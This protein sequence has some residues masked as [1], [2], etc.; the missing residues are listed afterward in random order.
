ML[1]YA[2][3]AVTFLVFCVGV[4]RDR[5]R[6][7]NAVLLG[8]SLVFALAAWCFTL[9][10]GGTLAGR[11]VAVAAVVVGALCVLVPAPLLLANG[12]TM[13]RKEGR[14]PA[15]LLSLLAG[16]GLFALAALLV[17]AFVLH[18]HTLLAI[19][20]TTAAIAGYVGFLFA[21][22]L[23]YGMLYGHLRVRRRTDYVVVLGAGLLGGERV[24]PLLAA[25]LDRGL[26]AQRV[27]SKRKREPFLLVS[28]GKGGDEALSEAEA[29]ARYV[30][31]KGFPERLVVC[32]DRSA[33]TEEN[34]RNSHALM[35]GANPRYRCVVVTSNYHVFRT[36]V[37]ARR[38]GVRG[39]VVGA[40]TASYFWPSAMIREFVALLVDY[41]R[42]NIALCLLLV[43]GG[44]LVWWL[45]R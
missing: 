4:L 27:L 1:A 26:T 6:F 9:V 43:L 40:P 17:A 3:A 22:V 39:H 36:A 28:G 18:A 21:C 5:R 42:T 44:A 8:L 33:T 35:A 23:A 30:R 16:L 10:H 24:S 45:S 19:A 15:N 29:M 12:V 25:R 20:V 37:T 14:G 32:E 11:D 41:R 2:P 7:S 38:V 13:V 34:L 31:A